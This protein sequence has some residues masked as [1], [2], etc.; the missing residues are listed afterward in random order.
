MNYQN[1]PAAAKQKAKTAIER[2]KQTG[3]RCA[4]QVGKVRAQQLSQSKPL[5]ETTIKRTYSYLSRGKTY[6]DSNN[7]NSCGSIS[8]DL[9]GGDPMLIYT[10]KV[11]KK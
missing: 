5:S 1:Y 8:Y 2:N 4:T 10:K 6:A 9:W 3:N 11:L 7:P